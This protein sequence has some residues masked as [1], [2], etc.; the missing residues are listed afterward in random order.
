MLESI[1][2][3]KA[4]EIQSQ[5]REEQWRQKEDLFYL[6]YGRETP[7]P[8]LWIERMIAVLSAH[9]KPI[10]KADRPEIGRS[11]CDGN[12]CGGQAA[13]SRI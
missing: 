2:L 5:A 7:R 11:A 4:I 6:D 10:E 3:A 9:R 12:G 1:A 13:C 8:F